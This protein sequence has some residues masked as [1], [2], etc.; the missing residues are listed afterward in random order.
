MFQ[1]GKAWIFSA[2][3]S[4]GGALFEYSRTSGADGTIYR[5]LWILGFYIA[6]HYCPTGWRFADSYEQ[7]TRDTLAAAPTERSPAF[8]D[9]WDRLDAAERKG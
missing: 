7:I 8:E 2:S 1:L 5:R 6:L 9:E 3:V 4:H